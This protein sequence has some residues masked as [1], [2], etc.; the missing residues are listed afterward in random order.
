MGL[1]SLRE[2]TRS[3]PAAQARLFLMW[4]R[5]RLAPGATA[6]VSAVTLPA[7]D[8]EGVLGGA[9]QGISVSVL[10]GTEVCRETAHAEHPGGP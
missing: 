5:H 3:Q 1:G 10:R 7:S 2:P 8:A 9:V 6:E 4:L